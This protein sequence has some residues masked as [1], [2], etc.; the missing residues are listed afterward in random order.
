MTRQGYVEVHASNN[1][2]NRAELLRFD[3]ELAI[4]FAM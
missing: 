4:A 3:Y 2:E 1:R